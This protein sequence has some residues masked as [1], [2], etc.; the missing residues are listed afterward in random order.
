MRDPKKLFKQ[1]FCTALAGLFIFLLLWVGQATFTTPLPKAEKPLI[2]YSTENL[3]DLQLVHSRAILSAKKSILLVIYSLND[4][5]VIHALRKKASEGIPVTVICD[6]EA[7]QGVEKRLGLKVETIFR[8]GQG[9]MHRKILVIDQ[10]KVWLGSANMTT[11]SLKMHGNLVI[12]L[13]NPE[14]ASVIDQQAKTMSKTGQIHK[15]QVKNFTTG[16]QRGEIYFL[17]KNQEALKKLRSLIQTAQ[18][19]IKVAMFTWTRHDLADD[20]IQANK[21]G[22]ATE[23][24]IDRSAAE[25]A[26]S[27]ILRKLSENGVT[28]HLSQGEALLHHK[29]MVVDDSILVNGSANWTKSAFD[30]NEDCFIVLYDLSQLQQDYLNS[31]WREI[32]AGS[33]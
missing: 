23:I 6:A 22:V 27:E 18:K 26:G 29:M 31:L 28:V 21:R 2:F 12:G 10:S 13:D 16:G 4:P 19:T 32:R 5:K 15:Q 25:S 14:L 9:L 7:S 17:P 1:T 30:R 33:E 11:T 24:A 3:D 20:I 8:K